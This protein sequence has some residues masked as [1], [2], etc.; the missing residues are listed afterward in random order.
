MGNVGIDGQLLERE[1]V[2]WVQ[3]K[4]SL[5]IAGGFFPMAFAAIDEAGINKDVG[6]VR[7][8]R[9]GDCELTSGPSVVEEPLIVIN[10]QSEMSFTRIRLEAQRGF[11]C[12]LGQ[13]KAGRSTV[14]SIPVNGV[15]HPGQQTPAD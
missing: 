6:I 3:L 7:Q 9:S 12:G 2:A 15:V 8:C 10:G 1:K 14:E 4:G 11:R 13:I 5:Q